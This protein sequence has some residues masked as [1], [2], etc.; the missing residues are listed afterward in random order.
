MQNY[1]GFIADVTNIALKEYPTR[2]DQ[3]IKTLV[4]LLTQRD[5]LALRVQEQ[6]RELKRLR[7]QNEDL[8][9]NAM[10]RGQIEDAV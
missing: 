8:L 4:Y 10:N 1:R 6:K 7:K 9:N 2:R 5:A 3:A